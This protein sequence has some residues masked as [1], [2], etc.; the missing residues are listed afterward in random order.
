MSQ[1]V[2]AYV[3]TEA[4]V[5]ASSLLPSNKGRSFLVHTLASALGF[6]DK[7]RGYS[8][9]LV[10]RPSPASRSDLCLYHDTDYMILIFTLANQEALLSSRAPNDASS[11]GLE[12]DCSFFEGLQ[13]YCVLVAGATLSAVKVLKHV[14]I[15]IVWDGGRHHAGKSRASGYCYINDVNL[16]ILSLRQL[17]PRPR[18]MY[19]DLD[20]HYPNG[21]ADAFQT[22]TAQ[23]ASVLILSIHHAS[24]GFYPASPNALLPAAGTPHLHTLS[25]PLAQGATNAT[26]HR[27]WKSCVQPVKE[28]FCPEFIIVQCGVDGLA[29]D[30]C[31]VF[32]WGL[33]LND[34]GSLGWCVNECLSWELRTVLLGGG[35]YNSANAARAWAYLTSIAC[36]SPLTLGDPIPDHPN[37]PQYGPS[38]TMEVDVGSFSD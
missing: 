6:F 21:V 23:T 5:K 28:A 12:D 33:D 26:F 10:F 7:S 9:I 25:I 8:N 27:I 32:N 3:V 30:P 35:G 2:V 16:G 37:F 34:E 36:G 22:Q 15:S 24:A 1:K 31:G 11:F 17:K 13:Q 38:F 4:L 18:V 19:I 14:D 20:L 29:G